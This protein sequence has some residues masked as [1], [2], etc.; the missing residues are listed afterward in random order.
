MD[1]IDTE[2]V[3]KQLDKRKEE[4]DKDVYERIEGVC[5]TLDE[6]CP[7]CLGDY[8]ACNRCYKR[9]ELI[10]LCKAHKVDVVI[11]DVIVDE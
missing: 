3:Y 7:C 2:K 6:V 5:I 9:T 11:E 8:D 1:M 10:M 4:M